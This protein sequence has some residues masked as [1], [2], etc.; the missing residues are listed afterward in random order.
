MLFKSMLM[1]GA[2]ATVAMA[3]TLGDRPLKF[4]CGAPE[5]T[6]EHIAI[7]KA[8]AAKEA[9]SKFDASATINVNV[10]FHI[11]AT[12]TSASG[13]YLTDTDINNQVKV[14]N[15]NYA[16]A[17]ISFTLK[18]VD[19]TVN[20]A[21]ATDSAEV[22]MKTALRKGT[23]SDLNI[24]FLK[25]LNPSG[26]LGYCY[27]PTNASKGSQDFIIDGC[28]ILYSTVP[29]GPSAPYNQG[30]TVTH[31]VGHWFGLYHTFQ[32][33]C[34]GNGD[35]VSDTPAQASSS[36]GCPTGRDSCPNQPGLDP[37]HNYM[38]YSD[39]ACYTEFTAG[40]V[41]R[42]KSFWTQYRG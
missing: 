22:A 17:G 40:Q 21:W 12:S 39:D 6:K 36:S 29:G 28:T 3:A 32:G 5:P 8:F 24:Y 33:G 41:Q 10:Y 14:M 30:K 18:G 16:P 23:Y 2:M 31:E 1:T 35:F 15:D 27:F 4:V 26:T 7:S 11:V 9:I 34:T 37:I 20:S 38:D 19:R 25:S 42:I 13:G